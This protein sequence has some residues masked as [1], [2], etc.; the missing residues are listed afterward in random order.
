[1]FRPMSLSA[2]APAALT[3]T[4]TRPPEIAAASEPTSASMVSPVIV[5][6]LS[7]PEASIAVSLMSAVTLP[8]AVSPV[9]PSP[10]ALCARAAPTATPTPA[11]PPATAAEAASTMA[12]M[13]DV[14][15]PST[16]TAPAPPMLELA[17]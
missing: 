8:G 9:E 10:I 5:L 15:E 11:M 16:V 6:T 13:V 2:A 4:P 3:E 17:I 12:L 7:A 14:S 1:M